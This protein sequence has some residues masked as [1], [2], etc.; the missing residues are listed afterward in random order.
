VIIFIGGDENGKELLL[1]EF[2]LNFE[3]NWLNLIQDSLTRKGIYKVYDKFIFVIID[4]MVKE[5][6]NKNY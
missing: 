2:Y 6:F 1:N 4:E 3:T 5:V